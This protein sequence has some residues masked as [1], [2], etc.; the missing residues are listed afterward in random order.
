[1]PAVLRIHGN[2]Q[3]SL[4][5][6]GHL[7]LNTAEISRLQLEFHLAFSLFQDLRQLLAQLNFQR[8]RLA[9]L[10]HR[11]S[12]TDFD[13]NVG[14]LLKDRSLCKICRLLLRLVGRLISTSA[15]RSCSGPALVSATSAG[16][17]SSCARI[18]G[19]SCGWAVS[20]AAAASDADT[21]GF[22]SSFWTPDVPV[23]DKMSRGSLP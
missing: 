10:F 11:L 6:P 15:F 3:R 2:A 8:P 14:D 22:C 12:L 13:W 4:L 7:Y 21:C 18:S 20:T 1:M 5:I 9:W 19:C 23:S 17:S 16:R